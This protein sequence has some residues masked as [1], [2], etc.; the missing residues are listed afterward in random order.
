[1]EKA[2]TLN[3][4]PFTLENI[5]QRTLLL[6]GG[7]G[8]GKTTT[9]KMLNA[10][11]A[12]S[13]LGLV[14]FDPLDV[15]RIKNFNRIRITRK[16]FEHG[17]DMAKLLAKMPHEHLIISF[18]DLLQTEQ[19]T[20]MDGLFSAWHPH[21]CIISIDEAHDFM[22]QSGAADVYCSELE[23]A[24]RHWRNKNCGFIMDTQRPAR[25]DKNAAELADCYGVYRMTGVND[26]RAVERM[27]SG[28]LPDKQVR[29]IMAD[30]P[31]LKF[32]ELYILDFRA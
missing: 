20:F 6:T 28:M 18:P 14:I 13:N 2:I 26:R 21:D 22:P 24:V 10:T 7:K 17:A 5:T 25:L 4:G 31:T 8:S 32:L 16:S 30:V 12:D 15:I 3:C 29:A 11:L 9:L 1:M 23:R 27:I 19:K